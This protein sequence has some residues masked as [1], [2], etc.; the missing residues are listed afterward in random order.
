MCKSH[1]EECSPNFVFGAQLHVTWDDFLGRNELNMVKKN[2]HSEWI[3]RKLNF[4]EFAQFVK[5]SIPFPLF[6]FSY[7]HTKKSFVQVKNEQFCKLKKGSRFL[8]FVV[9]FLF[10]CGCRW[11]IV[12]LAFYCFLACAKIGFE[13]DVHTPEH[14]KL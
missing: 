8:L 1:T 4:N 6:F 3:K 14:L 10:S 11:S 2:E 5:W 12:F 7:T 13:L 9:L